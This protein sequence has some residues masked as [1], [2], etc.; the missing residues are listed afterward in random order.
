MRWQALA[1]V[2]LALWVHPYPSFSG[3]LL[4]CICIPPLSDIGCSQLG[5]FL[6]H[7]R[8][9]AEIYEKHRKSRMSSPCDGTTF[10]DQSLKMNRGGEQE[11]LGLF[12]R[13]AMPTYVCEM[14]KCCCTLLNSP[15]A[16]C[17]CW[18]RRTRWARCSSD[19]LLSTPGHQEDLQH[20]GSATSNSF[21]PC[22]RMSTLNN[23]TKQGLFSRQQR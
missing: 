19:G 7:S 22:Y 16:E 4:L 8:P 10:L 21:I 23:I 15:L 17:L 5:G 20:A 12:S 6:F 1:D 3:A 18:S 14:K 11:R 2:A 13:M 9:E